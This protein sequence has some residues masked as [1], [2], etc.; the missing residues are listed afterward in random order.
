MRPFFATVMRR[1]WFLAEYGKPNRNSDAILAALARVE[2][3][4]HKI[5]RA[6]PASPAERV[7][8][9]LL[10]IGKAAHPVRDRL[11]QA[12]RRTTRACRWGD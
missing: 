8:I 1:R 5:R 6:P 10:E 3:A 2:A 11:D 7:R 9:K 4:V 12:G